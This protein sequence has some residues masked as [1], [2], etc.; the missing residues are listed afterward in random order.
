MPTKL[1]ADHLRDHYRNLTGNRLRSGHAH[2]IVAAFFGYGTRAA[3]LAERAYP[4]TALGQAEILIPDLSMMDAR[5][6]GIDEIPTDLPFTDDL[7]NLLA[8]FLQANGI[9]TG[10]VWLTRDLQEHIQVSVIPGHEMAIMDD[11]SGEM[12]ST[13]AYFDEVYV[14]EV[15]VD[16]AGDSIV[17]SVSGSVNGETHDDRVFCGDSI[18]F[19]T[20]ITLMRVAGRVAF[21]APMLET[22]GSVDTS[23]Y[24]DDDGDEGEGTEADDDAHEGEDA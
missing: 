4:L 13:N 21:A 1:C 2:E 7:V 11:L 9:F 17:A 20:T 19:E 10:E 8:T 12:A 22:S 3:L 14:E 24:E 6:D 15:D 18:N 16:V 23:Y 5:I